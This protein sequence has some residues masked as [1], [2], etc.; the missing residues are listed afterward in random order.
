MSLLTVVGQLVNVLYSMSSIETFS[1][2]NFVICHY[3]KS[4]LLNGA[5]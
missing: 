5:Q 1:Y 4:I 3:D 2:V